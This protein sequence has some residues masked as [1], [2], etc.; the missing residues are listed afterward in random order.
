MDHLSYLLECVRTG[1]LNALDIRH[2]GE[3]LM[4]VTARG[5][6][7]S[8]G[9]GS[10]A[11][12][13]H[14]A[15]ALIYDQ[16]RNRMI[17]MERAVCSM[18]VLSKCPQCED[19]TLKPVGSDKRYAAKE[20]S[21]PKCGD[22][23]SSIASTIKGDRQWRDEMAMRGSRGVAE[24]NELVEMAAPRPLVFNPS[25]VIGGPPASNQQTPPAVNPAPWPAQDG[26]G[27]LVVNVQEQAKRFESPAKEHA[28]EAV[29][30]QAEPEATTTVATE[31]FREEAPTKVEGPH[32]TGG[33]PA[34]AL[35][36]AQEIF[37]RAAKSATNASK[38]TAKRM[39]ELFAL[40]KTG[41]EFKLAATKYTENFSYFVVQERASAMS[42]LHAAWSRLYTEEDADMR[43]V[44][45]H[46][47][48]H[49]CVKASTP[50]D[51]SA[52]HRIGAA[53]RDLWPEAERL[54][55]RSAYKQAHERL[56]KAE[57]ATAQ[58]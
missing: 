5:G 36:S 47:F 25:S 48:G 29:Q 16:V 56:S 30:Q 17:A 7:C 4:E 11:M 31:G 38:M 1:A 41:R 57:A 42:A 49:L 18:L 22:I 3:G 20:F 50:T 40:A 14:E 2:A 13:E 35:P 55:A 46:V 45:A 54:V 53:S 37:D 21:C 28:V 39:C 12:P 52:L 33:D 10:G 58:T 26:A 23:I 8:P 27:P 6:V 34:K 32:P 51:L 43:T 9:F 44:D 19:S 15:F 24:P